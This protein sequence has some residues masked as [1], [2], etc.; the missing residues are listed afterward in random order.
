M[1]EERAVPGT[2]EWAELGA[3]HLARYL[4]A[5]DYARG[6]R[7][8]DAGTGSGYGAALLK[9]HGAD[10]VRAIDIDAET[11]RQA[12]ERFALEGVTF[13][14]DDCETLAQT[15]G[16]FDLICNFENIEHLP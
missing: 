15:A 1:A 13:A 9:M 8:L 10:S 16:P 11:I 7:V 6:R 12:E 3:P 14:V 2:V 4:F 5:V